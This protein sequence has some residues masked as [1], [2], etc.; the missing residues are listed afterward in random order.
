MG[1]CVTV[2]RHLKCYNTWL[3][4]VLCVLPYIRRERLNGV[5]TLELNTFLDSLNGDSK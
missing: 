3:S 5:V 2:V 4:L 1:V